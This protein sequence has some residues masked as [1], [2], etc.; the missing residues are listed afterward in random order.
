[1]PPNTTSAGDGN[2]MY[3]KAGIVSEA[4]WNLDRMV[5]CRVMFLLAGVVSGWRADSVVG[6]YVR[7]V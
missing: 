7:P 4:G 1:M 5:E 6:W 2:I 3:L